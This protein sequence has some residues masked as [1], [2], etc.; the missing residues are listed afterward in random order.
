MPGHLI[1]ENN[2]IGHTHHA[3]RES[4]A[5]RYAVVVL[6][7]RVFRFGAEQ[8][9]SRAT[10]TVTKAIPVI[11]R[12]IFKVALRLYV[13]RIEKIHLPTIPRNALGKSGSP[14][15]LTSD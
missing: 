14:P 13:V 8:P 2:G 3:G 11:R 7:F 6:V 1:I 4:K 15:S 10:E 9:F 5:P 12:F